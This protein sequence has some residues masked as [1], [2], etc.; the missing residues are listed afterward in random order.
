MCRVSL[1]IIFLIWWHW[2]FPLEPHSI[3]RHV[4]PPVN[5]FFDAQKFSWQSVDTFVRHR[6]NCIR[7]N[8]VRWPNETLDCYQ[9]SK[10]DFRD[11]RK[12][13]SFRVVNMVFNSHIFSN[14]RCNCRL[15]L[16]RYCRKRNGLTSFAGDCCPLSCTSLPSFSGGFLMVF[17][18]ASLIILEV[19][20][21]V[22]W[23]F[24]QIFSFF[25]ELCQN[26]AM[27]YCFLKRGEQSLLKYSFYVGL[28]HSYGNSTQLP[29]R[30]FSF[31]TRN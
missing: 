10:P 26:F 20:F 2:S 22:C 21:S 3:P 16:P 14:F 24:S 8:W 12:V 11:G 31:T 7:N 23:L 13:L 15:I 28:A 19:Q 18:K 9:N 29:Y 27:C 30:L 17:C 5:R 1:V 4:V 6:L 25:S